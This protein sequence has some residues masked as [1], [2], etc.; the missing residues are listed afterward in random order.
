M[1]KIALVIIAAASLS[2]CS[3]FKQSSDWADR[4]FFDSGNPQPNPNQPGNNYPYYY[5]SAAPI[6]AN[7]KS[8]YNSPYPPAAPGANYGAAAFA[9]YGQPQYAPNPSSPQ[10]VTGGY[11]S[12]PNAPSVNVQFGSKGTDVSSAKTGQYIKNPEPKLPKKN[13]AARTPAQQPGQPLPT[14]QG[15]QGQYTP[16]YGYPQA[17]QPP[18]P[19]VISPVMP[20]QAP[21]PPYGYPAPAPQAYGQPPAYA[22]QAYAPQGYPQP[23]PYSQPQY[24]YPAQP[25]SNPYPYSP[26]K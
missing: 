9:P 6:D 18:V 19:P 11:G 3:W 2:G 4:T 16:Q 23:A 21:P 10:A 15:T 26:N 13:E 5:T 25:Y 7:E 20:E 1:K 14:L 8:A 12:D 22:P 17:P 24:Q